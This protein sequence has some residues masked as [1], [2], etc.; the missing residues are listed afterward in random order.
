MNGKRMCMWPDA[1]LAGMRGPLVSMLHASFGLTVVTG[2]MLFI[3]DPLGVG[4]HTMF[5]PKLVLITLGLALAHG[6]GALAGPVFH[7]APRGG[8]GVADGVAGGGGRVHLEPYGSARWMCGGATGRRR[9]GGS[10][11]E[12]P[13]ARSRYL[14][15]WRSGVYVRMRLRPPE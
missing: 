8:R 15:T 6:W 2:V 9:S 4:L 3:Y 11:Q 13:A 12:L 5:L 14:G 7:A 10:V 1:S